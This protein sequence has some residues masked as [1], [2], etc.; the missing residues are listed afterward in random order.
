MTKKKPS[1]KERLGR[2]VLASSDIICKS[3]LSKDRKKYEISKEDFDHFMLQY[4]IVM[5]AT[6]V[7]GDTTIKV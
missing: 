7:D 3:K 5:G 4:E 1:T 2:L 6:D